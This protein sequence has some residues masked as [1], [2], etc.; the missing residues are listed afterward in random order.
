[1]VETKK[2]NKDMNKEI[3]NQRRG[4]WKKRKSFE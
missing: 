1:M 2:Q 3:I 4:E